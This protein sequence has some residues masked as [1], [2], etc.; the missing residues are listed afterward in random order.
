MQE[1]IF[2]LIQVVVKNFM[3]FKEETSF[4][5]IGSADKLYQDGNIYETDKGLRIL[6]STAIFGAN[7]SGKSNFLK[8]VLFMKRLVINSSKETQ[9][10]EQINVEPFI[11][12]DD[13]ENKPSLIEIVFI[14]ENI[15]YRYGIEVTKNK[16]ISEWLFAKFTNRETKLFLRNGKDFEIGNKFKEGKDLKEKTRTNALFLSVSAQFN[17]EIS[18]KIIEWFHKLN[19]ISVLGSDYKNVTVN[20]LNKENKQGCMRD[21]IM[22][23]VKGAD[24]GI[25]D[26]LLENKEVNINEIIKNMSPNMAK[27]FNEK[28]KKSENFHEVQ[29]KSVHNKYNN[30]NKLIGVTPFDF[31]IESDGTKKLFALLGPIIDTLYKGKVLFIDEIETSLHPILLEEIIKLF[32]NPEKID[33]GAQLIFT[34]H[35]TS[36]LSANL[37]R[38]DQLW[39]V[40]KNK[41]GASEMFSLLEFQEHVRKDAS[42]EK[43]YLRGRYGAVPEISNFSEWGVEECGD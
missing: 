3:S 18:G 24:T 4:S 15:Q 23:I 42:L 27:K 35:N 21:K 40:G 10:N 32:C 12:C 26:I 41:Y 30:N 2:M 28:L 5:M 14:M 6:K 11:L 39:F 17:G 36:L 37:F 20:L 34:T 9:L 8:A 38:R 43:N 19:V 16:I 29:I 7:G 1:V 25:I 31:N 13:T 33:K 22:N